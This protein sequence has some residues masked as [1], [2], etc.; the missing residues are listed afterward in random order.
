MKATAKTTTRQP[1]R[2]M[3]SGQVPAPAELERMQRAIDAAEDAEAAERF[4]G[5]GINSH[6]ISGFDAITN[7]QQGLR[8]LDMAIEALPHDD[9]NALYFLTKALDRV[10]EEAKLHIADALR[11]TAPGTPAARCLP[12]RG[13]DLDAQ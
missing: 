7:M 10:V 1:R 12:A 6:L 4:R 11:L 13:I 2:A 8:A 5:L 9:E 3:Q